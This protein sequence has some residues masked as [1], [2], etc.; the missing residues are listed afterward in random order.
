MSHSGVKGR[1]QRDVGDI[2]PHLNQ[3]VDRATGRSQ[4]LG[5]IVQCLLRLLLKRRV[6]KLCAIARDRQL[7]GNKHKTIRLH[8]VAVMTAGCRHGVGICQNDVAGHDSAPYLRGTKI[9]RCS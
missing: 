2:D 7:T 9:K 3:P 5:N 1:P 6:H 8:G 4:R